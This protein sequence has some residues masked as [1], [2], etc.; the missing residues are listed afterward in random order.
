VH[1][2]ASVVVGRDGTVVRY[3]YGTSFLPKDLTLALIE[4][5]EGRI[6]PTIRKVV[7]FCFNYDPAQKTYVFNLLRVSATAVILTVFTFFLFLLFGGR[8]KRPKKE[9]P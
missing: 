8:K 5:D 9:Q 4:A 6:G 3:L 2:V 7:D 1:P